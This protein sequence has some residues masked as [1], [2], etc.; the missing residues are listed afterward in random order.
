MLIKLMP[1]QIGE[2][3]DEI[4]EAMLEAVPPIAHES[5]KK[6]IMVLE[7]LLTNNMQCWLSVR[8]GEE[9]NIA[10]AIIVTCINSDPYS[11]TRSLMIYSLTVL[12][13]TRAESWMSGI[14]ALKKYAKK[15]KCARV[16][17]YADNKQIVKI[18]FIAI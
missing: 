5:E 9:R 10:D 18:A 3:W 13:L 4:K 12:T 16:I 8:Q 14:E 2:H 15:K 1:E 7:G 6:M 17:A 11:G